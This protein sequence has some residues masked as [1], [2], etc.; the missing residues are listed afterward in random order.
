MS[1][2]KTCEAPVDE[3]NKAALAQI[4]QEI[5]GLEKEMNARLSLIRRRL[6]V[7]LGG[8]RTDGPKVFELQGPG[9]K[10]RK[11]EMRGL[12]DA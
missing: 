5:N 4:L 1:K 7:V 10:I 8:K 9:G 2:T 11:I 12:T 3:G 6:T